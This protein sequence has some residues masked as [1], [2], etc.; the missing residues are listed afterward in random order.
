MEISKFSQNRECL[1]YYAFD[2][3]D[4]IFYMPTKIHME[5]KI[6]GEWIPESVSTHQF[7]M[8]RGDSENWRI[9]SG[10]PEV[11][12][13]EF[14]DNG[15]RGENAFIEDVKISCGGRNFAPS[16]GDFKEC[17]KGGRL[18]AIITA[19]GHESPTIRNG[20]EWVIDNALSSDDQYE[21]YN[22]LLMYHYLFRSQ[23]E[24]PR[25]IPPELG[26]YFSQN[27]LVKSY[28]DNCDFVGVSAPSRLGDAQNPEEAKKKAV[29]DFK[30]KINNFANNIGRKACIGFS[31]DDKKNIDSI[32][33]LFDQMDN[34]EFASIMKMTLKWTKEPRFTHVSTWDLKNEANSQ[35]FDGTQANVL[36]FTKWNNMTQRLYPKNSWSRQDD[37]LNDFNNKLGQASSVGKVDIQPEQTIGIRKKRRL[38]RKRIKKLSDILK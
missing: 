25:R 26:G 24:D 8:V 34:E 18:F 37:N 23:S 27:P 3:D 2:W 13:S 36:P 14:R 30:R 32:E 21:M 22:H 4:N 6:D 31:D 29:I 20:C 10:N 1:L 7:S 28:L 5:H 33:E 17:L 19:R 38:K 15:P 16:W 9:L 35:N 11:A 12:F